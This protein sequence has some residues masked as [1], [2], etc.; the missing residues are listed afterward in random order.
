MAE[1]L[2][3]LKNRIKSASNISKIAKAMEM[4][5]ASKI[6]KAQD[7]VENNRPYSEKI[8]EIV[9]KA[10]ASVD[11]ESFS[12]EYLKINNS[13]KKLLV[14]ISPDKGLC[15]SLPTNLTKKLSELI[16]K[17]TLIITI[18][19]KIAKFASKSGGQLIASFPMGTALPQYSNIFPIIDLINQY[20]MGGKVGSV[21][22]VLTEFKSIFLQVP[23]VTQLLPLIPAI[24]QTN[25]EKI[26]PTG[27]SFE[28]NI[29]VVLQELLP[30]FIEV[31]LYYY[32]IHAFTS[33]QAARMIA[34]QN[35]KNNALDI[36]DFLTL[37][38]NKARQAKITNELLDL[39]NVQYI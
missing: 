36:A 25:I 14:A 31:K 24:G 35:A 21:A 27:Y 18:G 9:E 4:I 5:S 39:A 16:D 22:I 10:L 1:N 8:T 28:P 6:K 17:D 26:E 33:E 37:T 19:K 34:M 15:G 12:H 38:Y 3:I 32:L 20:F 13:N 11:L 29:N 30:Y 2:Q 7:A 23:H